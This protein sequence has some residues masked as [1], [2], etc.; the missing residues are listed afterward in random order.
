MSIVDDCRRCEAELQNELI[1][2]FRK[3]TPRRVVALIRAG[4][5]VTRYWH[6][7]AL[8]ILGF[9]CVEDMPI[10]HTSIKMAIFAIFA[11]CDY[12]REKRGR[13][14]DSVIPLRG[15]HCLSYDCYLISR[16]FLVNRDPYG[17]I[18]KITFMG[19]VKFPIN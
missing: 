17:K 19:P 7:R 16:F 8:H 12:K 11:F 1:T 10:S 13:A 14:T 6:W 5:D 2:A 18:E 4:C 9:V 3:G 15:L